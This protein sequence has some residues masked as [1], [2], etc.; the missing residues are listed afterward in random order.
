MLSTHRLK[1]ARLSTAKL[2]L[3]IGISLSGGAQAEYQSNS[4]VSES[5]FFDSNLLRGEKISPL[6]AERLNSAQSISPG[7]YSLDV[8]LNGQYIENRNIEVREYQSGKLAP[9]LDRATL[10][11]LDIDEQSLSDYD[12]CTSP[13][14]SSS[15]IDIGQ[16]RLNLEIP[17]TFLR[18]KPRGYVE[19]SDLDPGTTVGF[20]NY[21]SNYYHVEYSDGLAETQ[22]SAFASINGGINLGMWQYRNQS[23]LSWDRQ[24]GYDY[25][26]IL[27]YVQRAL[28]SLD[29]K[30]VIGQT[31]TTGQLFSGLSYTGFSLSSDERM[32]P[33][34]QRGYAPTIRGIATTN[35]KVSVS[36]SGREIYQLTVPPGPFEISDLYPTS[37]SGDLYVKITEAD[38]TTS[39]FTVPYS[40]VPES[41]R[42]GV[43]RYGLSIGKTRDVGEDS[44]FA[45][46]TWQYGITNSITSNSGL[47]VSN[48]YQA[49]TLGGVYSNIYGAFGS[50]ATYSRANLPEDGYRD[51]WMAR[52]SYS[53][54]FE[55]T[56]TA[57]YIA[58]YRYSTAGYRDLGDVLGVREAQK[59]ASSWTST[60]Y[61]QQSRIEVTLNQS[62]GDNGNV[63]ISGS[64]QNYRD[65]RKRDTQFQ[66]G[67]GNALNNGVSFNVSTSRQRLGG[68]DTQA[69]A[70]YRPEA[71]GLPGQ[72]YFASSTVGRVD[73]ITSISLSFPLGRQNYRNNSISSTYTHSTADGS[74]YQTNISGFSAED[75]SLSYSAGVSHLEMQHET[76]WNGNLQK[77]LPKASLGLSASSGSR[78]WQAS[79]NAQ[80][81]VVAHS[82]GLTLGPYLGETFALIEAKGATGARLMNTQDTVIDSNGY[83][84]VPAITPYRYSNIALNP[85]GMSNDVELVDGEKRVAPYAGAAVKVRFQ[86]RGG[87]PM[88]IKAT[89]KDG[90]SIPMG[91]D[92]LNEDGQSIGMVGQHGLTYVRVQNPEG[93]LRIRWGDGALD[94]CQLS[95]KLQQSASAPITRASAVCE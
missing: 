22:N 53:R 40:A 84:L 80:G 42:P 90:G 7:K 47:R 1:V 5:Y 67:Y 72:G 21:L 23:N 18:R 65:G 88:L 35:A 81:A 3:T 79:A 34:S 68:Y 49:L 19:P 61:Q 16:L 73:T 41:L 93:R 26:S 10:K 2:S 37:Y 54:T 46:A 92:A 13:I 76:I 8:Y 9:C 38:G 51:G 64:T 27:N 63:Y 15:R 24:R 28:P 78:Y 89:R 62:L 6:L 91:S 39:N 52:I 48:G 56:S 77:R 60:T 17:Q 45:D 29:S 71:L 58:G 57:V 11:K 86:T 74:Q 75:Q 12:G 70:G 44:H 4:A 59:H 85:E 25:N 87:Y 94:W 31:F 95:Y 55:P 30:M 32:L 50:D 33:D 69:P 43:W 82:G 83:A 66:I 36:Q 14:F 20:L